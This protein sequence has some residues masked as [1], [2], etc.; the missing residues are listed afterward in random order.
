MRGV[1]PGPH[2]QAAVQRETDSTE[3]LLRADVLAPGQQVPDALGQGF[4]K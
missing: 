3:H 4:V 1:L 2:E